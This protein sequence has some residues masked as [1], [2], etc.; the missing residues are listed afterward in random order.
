MHGDIRDDWKINEN[1]RKA[2]QARDSPHE[3]LTLALPALTKTGEL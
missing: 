3:M 1:E 2:Q